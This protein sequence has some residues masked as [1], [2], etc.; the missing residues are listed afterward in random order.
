MEMPRLDNLGTR[1]NRYALDLTISRM[2]AMMSGGPTF[3]R[4]LATVRSSGSS[5]VWY[6]AVPPDCN[7]LQRAVST[8]GFFQVT[9]IRPKRSASPS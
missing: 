8:S 9:S 2:T 3:S 1:R 4:H 5:P 7:Q 6:L